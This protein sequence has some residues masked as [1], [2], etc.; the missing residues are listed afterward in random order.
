MKI[1]PI[2]EEVKE[3]FDGIAAMVTGF[4]NN[5]DSPINGLI[6]SGDA[7][8]GKTFTVS[9]ALIDSGHAQHTEYIKGGKI[10]AASLYVKMYLN[11]NNHRIMVIDDCDL[12]H[13]SDRRDIITTLLGAV[14]IGHTRTVA[15]E[16]AQ[17]NSMMVEYKVPYSF[18]FN[19]KLIWITNDTKQTMQKPLRQ[20]YDAI[21]SRFN[22][23]ECSFTPEQKYMYTMYL[24]EH[25]DMLGKNCE[26]YKPGYS[27]EIIDKTVEYMS[28]NYRNLVEI[29]PRQ[30]VKIAE[31]FRIYPDPKMH[32]PMLRQLWR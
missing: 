9:K 27:P 26:A 17:K 3:R 13:R 24:V 18:T 6:V 5:P 30:A 20:W 23:A 16:L 10:T 19:G 28:K 1:N 25:I 2:A 22:F 15:W 11:R 29:T 14:E 21:L 4:V 12:I 8:T 7:G 32:G 31:I